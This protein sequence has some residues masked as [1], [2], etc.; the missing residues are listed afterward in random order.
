MQ[1][2]KNREKITVFFALFFYQ[3]D[4]IAYK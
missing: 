4:A 2:A 1:L 3:A